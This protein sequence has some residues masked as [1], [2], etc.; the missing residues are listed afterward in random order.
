MTNS[1]TQSVQT[2]YKRPQTD[3]KMANMLNKAT[4]R[5]WNKT[6]E[7]D[8]MVGAEPNGTKKKTVKRKQMENRCNIRWTDQTTNCICIFHTCLFQ[9]GCLSCKKDFAGGLPSVS[10]GQL[11]YTMKIKKDL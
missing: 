4:I 7:R 10:M 2:A 8:R 3:V 11:F 5:R 1:V 9:S 6:T